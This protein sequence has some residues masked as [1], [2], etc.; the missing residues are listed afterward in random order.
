MREVHK[1]VFEDVNPDGMD[2]WISNYIAEVNQE[3]LKEAAGHEEKYDAALTAAVE[4]VGGSIKTSLQTKWSVDYRSKIA[5]YDSPGG[6]KPVINETEF[7][8]YESSKDRVEMRARFKK[9][10]EETSAS[11]DRQIIQIMLGASDDYGIEPAVKGA[12]HPPEKF[13]TGNITYLRAVWYAA[14]CYMRALKQIYSR[15]V[16]EDR[17]P[18]SIF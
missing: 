3:L 13:D 7:R 10:L 16:S 9:V 8:E 1:A 14:D 5:G 2:D 6:L 15:G 4:I 17:L 12:K 18:D 11:C